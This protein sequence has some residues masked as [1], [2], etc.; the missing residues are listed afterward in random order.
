MVSTGGAGVFTSP[1][2]PLYQQLIL[3]MSWNCFGLREISFP[4]VSK[5]LLDVGTFATSHQ[6]IEVFF[7]S[8]LNQA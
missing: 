5:L 8:L 7:P 3:L 2:V 1:P 4:A 6:E